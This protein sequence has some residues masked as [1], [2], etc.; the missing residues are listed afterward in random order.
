MATGLALCAQENTAVEGS[1]GQALTARRNPGRHASPSESVRRRSLS[2][3]DRGHR[4]RCA[5]PD[6]RGAKRQKRKRCGAAASRTRASADHELQRGRDG[7][8]R[9]HDGAQSCQRPGLSLRSRKH[10]RRWH[11]IA[12]TIRWCRRRQSWRWWLTR[13]LCAAHTRGRSAAAARQH[14]DPA[15][16]Q[17]LAHRRPGAS[18][19][20]RLCAVQ[21]AAPLQV[22]RAC[23]RPALQRTARHTTP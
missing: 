6:R 3:H 21:R 13:G 12:S 1:C 20:R 9:P 18:A 5:Q 8:G 16:Q 22:T 15:P 4:C 14:Q 2:R 19:G 7:A 23:G 17:A 10:A 11:A